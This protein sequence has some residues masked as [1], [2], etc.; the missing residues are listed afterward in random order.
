MSCSPSEQTRTDPRQKLLDSWANHVI[1]PGYTE[2]VK[3]AQL[4]EEATSELC[5]DSSSSLA[6]RLQAARKA[7]WELREPWKNNEVIKFGPYREEPL[8]IGPKVDFWPTRIES[9]EDVLTSSDELD[10]MAVSQ[11]GTVNRGM[12]VAEYLLYPVDAD[13]ELDFAESSRRCEYLLAVTQD[14]TSLGESMLNAWSPGGENYAAELTA[15]QEGSMFGDLRGALS[16]VVNRLA[17]TVEDM[18]GDKIGRPN[19][20]QSGGEVQP[21][22]VESRPSARSIQDLLDVLRGV[23]LFYFGADAPEEA[24]GLSDYL[25]SEPRDFNAEMRSHLDSCRKALGAID[26]FEE[27]LSESPEEIIAAQEALSEL[28]RFIQVDVVSELGF[29]VSFN[30]NDGD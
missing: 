20:E 15:P 30:D 23:E 7:W 8:R 2:F 13:E 16:E 24:L 3:R 9:I 14:I 12:P 19:G 27:A 1:L 10:E 28:Q 21:D 22:L 17:F 26:P 6:K 18:R 11:M 25:P 5:A 29:S 4:L